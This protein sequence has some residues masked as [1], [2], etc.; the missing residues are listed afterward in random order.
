MKIGLLKHS[1]M[2][3]FGVT[4]LKILQSEKDQHTRPNQSG[5][6]PGCGCRDR[7]HNLRRTLMQHWSFEQAADLCFV[8]FASAFDCVH[9]DS[10][11]QIMAAD[12]M[13]QKLLGLI[14]VYYSST[15][16]KVRA[17]GSDSMPF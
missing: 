8:D 13:P 16:M 17:R 4:L 7:M 2:K 3:V 15:K 9:G 1:K 11:W 6:R 12:G 10:L 14:K 5:F